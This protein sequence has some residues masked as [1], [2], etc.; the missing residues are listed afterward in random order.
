MSEIKKNSKGCPD[1]FYPEEDKRSSSAEPLY[2][3]LKI[4]NTDVIVLKEIWL[5]YCVRE[6]S[7]FFW[8]IDLNWKRFNFSG[9][10][11]KE[12]FLFLNCSGF[13]LSSVQKAGEFLK[14]FKE[15]QEAAQLDVTDKTT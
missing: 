9:I 14:K 11:W 2:Y 13:D 8:L 7:A 6:I 12:W 5:E 4:D 3:K 15:K 10:N 1:A